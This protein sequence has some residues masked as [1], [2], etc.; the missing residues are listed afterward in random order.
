MRI[1][2]VLAVVMGSSGCVQLANTYSHYDYT[3]GV[4]AK[5]KK[6]ALG[7]SGS[8]FNVE[9]RTYGNGV[10]YGTVY[11]NAFIGMANLSTSTMRWQ[12]PR[13]NYIQ[14]I[15]ET[16]GYITK[17]ES[18]EYLVSIDAYDEIPQDGEA[19]RIL[20]HV[21]T[22]S[23][24][25]EASFNYRYRIR[26]YHARSGELLTTG[27]L[28][29]V[30]MIRVLGFQFPPFL[31]SYCK[32]NREARRPDVELHRSWCHRAADFIDEFMISKSKID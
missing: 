29:N 3:E 5:S 13:A 28:D 14:D 4:C 21:C 6:I 11:Q 22:L 12:D 7:F 15:L 18:P 23:F 24:I 30:G 31:F 17:S 27:V 8:L 19:R 1:A 26:I 2:F 16:K 25:T 20:L 10:A 32:E 9:Y